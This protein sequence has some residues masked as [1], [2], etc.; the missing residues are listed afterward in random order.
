MNEWRV[1][2]TLKKMV[3][4]KGKIPTRVLG[5]GSIDEKGA[6]IRHTSVTFSDCVAHE[7]LY[8]LTILLFIAGR[9]GKKKRQ[10][11]KKR[12]KREGSKQR[13]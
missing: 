4:Y 6:I 1:C 2:N 13:E 7:L 8:C 11:K 12:R 10:K 9:Y 5:E 3:M